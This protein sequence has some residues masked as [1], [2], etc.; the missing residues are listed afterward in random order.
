MP[1]TR[2][3]SVRLCACGLRV[4]VF[5][6]VASLAPRAGADEKQACV[7]AV[8]RA[9]VDRLDGRL[10]A[11]REGFVTCAR[12]VCPD[13]IRVD[14][15]RWVAEVDASLPTVVI[16]AVW[17]DGHD[18]AGLTVTLDGQPL[19]GAATGRAVALD[20][21]SHAFRFDAPGAAPVEASYMIR[22]GE[23]NRILHLTLRPV[24]ASASLPAPSSAASASTSP[25]NAVPPDLWRA[26]EGGAAARS[27]PAPNRPVPT[28]AFVVG[29]VALASFGGFVYAGLAGT[30][31]LNHLRDACAPSCDPTRV[32]AAR[33]EILIGDVLGYI[34]LAAAGV[35][36]WL[37]LTRPAVPVAP[38]TAAH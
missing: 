5:V 1:L 37:V 18:V 13:A 22:E 9:Q 21:G 11:A 8:E 20:P 32:D 35:A 10:R 38:D 15:T 4:A 2:A 29:G 30:G 26:S 23:K 7:R 33:R 3:S 25:S 17:A 27:R 6:L 24:D 28:S 36:T 31:E 34:A 19:T 12:A 16:D 14:C